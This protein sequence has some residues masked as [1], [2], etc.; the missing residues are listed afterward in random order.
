M[1][2]RCRTNGKECAVAREVVESFKREGLT[3]IPRGHDATIRGRDC[4]G[5]DEF[6]R[7]AL[8]T[9]NA[10]WWEV[11]EMVSSLPVTG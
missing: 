8:P 6:L 2:Y 10:H 4:L 5:R 3:I 1:R 7:E 9:L 11:V